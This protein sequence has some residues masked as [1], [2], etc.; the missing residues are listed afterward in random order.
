MADSTQTVDLESTIAALQGGLASLPPEAAVSAIEGWQQQ[1]QG[2]EIA[3]TLGELK[4]ALTGNKSAASIG[5]ILADLGAQT[6]TA[7]GSAEGSAADKL[8]RLGQ[9]LAQAGNSIG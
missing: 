6:S 3:E 9:L 5:E 8:Q 2:T 4:L 1:L 7:A